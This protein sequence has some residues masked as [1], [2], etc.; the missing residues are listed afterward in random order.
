MADG[1]SAWRHISGAAL[2][3][4]ATAAASRAVDGARDIAAPPLSTLPAA[5]AAY[6]QTFVL[7][8]GPVFALTKN[9]LGSPTWEERW[10]ALTPT[11]LIVIKV[12]AR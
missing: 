9:W 3:C 2:P 5:A 6:N 11:N 8:E 4:D 1:S 12:R 7:A 10:L